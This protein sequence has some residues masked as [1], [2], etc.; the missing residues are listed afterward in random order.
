MNMKEVYYYDLLA[1]EQGMIRAW[2]HTKRMCNACIKAHQG[3]IAR[4]KKMKRE[5]KEKP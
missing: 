3:E 1:S 4:L 2:Q 5:R